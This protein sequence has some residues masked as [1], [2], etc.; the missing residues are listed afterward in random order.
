[1]KPQEQAIIRTLERLGSRDDELDQPHLAEAIAMVIWNPD[2]GSIDPESPPRD[3]GLRLESMADRIAPRYL[4][5]YKNLPPH[6][7][8]E[9]AEAETDVADDGSGIV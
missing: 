7:V 2:D 3:S 8:M 4:D 5:R 9:Q 6:E 1:L